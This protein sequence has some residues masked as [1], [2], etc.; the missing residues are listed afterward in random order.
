LSRQLADTDV[1]M[2]GIYAPENID[3]PYPLYKQVRDVNPVFWDRQMGEQGAWMITGY[4]PSLVVLMDQQ[5]FSARRPQWDPGT[6]APELASPMKALHTQ[7]FVSDQPDHGR[8]RGMLIQPFKP[9]AV[10]RL[11]P[12][13]EQVANELLDAVADKGEMDLMGEFAAALP[14]AM[15]CQVLGVPPS[16]K[17]RYWRRILSWGLLVDEHPMSKEKPEH[18]LAHMAK[19]MDYFRDQLAKRKQNRTDDLLQSLSDSWEDGA[20]ASEEELLGN[21]IF[22]LTAGQ[23]TTAHQIGNTLLSLLADQHTDVYRQ[24]TENPGKVSSW[25]PEFMRYDSSVQLTK[26]RALQPTELAG[27]QI[28]QGDEMYVWMGAAHR[29]PEAFPDPDR[30]NLTR[31][32]MQTLSLGHGAHYC[33]GGPLGQA[34]NEIAV[35]LFAE[36]IPNPKVRFD[37]VQRM[38]TA[39]FRGP[40]QVPL[41]FG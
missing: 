5:L 15:V 11:R 29:D 25:T 20:F 37:K 34:V 33:L 41:T 35:Q 24:V 17:E 30:I 27:E 31:R 23:T 38:A 1:T 18:H 36:R 16:D 21:L 12:V 39:T 32:K 40:Y 26:R 28:A 8:L 7:V 3:D 9:R 14:S 22:M 19:Y 13:I 2:A 10:E 4:E 6:M